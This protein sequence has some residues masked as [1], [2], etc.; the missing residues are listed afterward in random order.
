MTED[1]SPN[2]PPKNVREILLATSSKEPVSVELAV[3]AGLLTP[4]YTPV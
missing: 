3:A 2:F 4:Y 1:M